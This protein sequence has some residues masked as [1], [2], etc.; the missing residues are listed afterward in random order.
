M[1]G[2]IGSGLHLS[3]RPAT[4]ALRVAAILLGVGLVL[5][6]GPVRAQDAD[7]DD[8]K[9]FEEKLMDNLMSGLGGKK[10]EDGSIEYRERSPLVVPSKIDLPPPQTGKSKLAPNWPKDPDIAERA[11]ARERAKQKRKTPEE[12]RMPLMPNELAQRTPKSKGA[13][14]TSS[15]GNNNSNSPL[16]MMPSQLGYVG[17]LFSNPFGSKTTETE[18]FVSEP[19][20]SELTQPPSGYQTPSSNYAYGV[21]QLKAPKEKCDAASGR[22]EK[23]WD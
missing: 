3:S 7:E 1:T 22:C 15:P 9:T 8:G 19:E 20:R 21:G 23:I 11:A 18:K 16:M 2:G 4:R 13:Q 12:E 14:D 17:G 6:A 10:L 5:G